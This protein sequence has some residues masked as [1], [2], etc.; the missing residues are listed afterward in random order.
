M[1]NILKIRYENTL[2]SMEMIKS[3]FGLTA[4]P[5]PSSR[6]SRFFIESSS[7]EKKKIIMEVARLANEDQRKL[8][9]ESQKSK[10]TR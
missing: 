1:S 5:K 7:R 4:K 8:Y 3:F 10:S 6:F 2:E 9:Y